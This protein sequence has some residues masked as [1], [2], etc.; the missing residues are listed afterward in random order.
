MNSQ[1]E[2]LAI[3]NRIGRFKSCIFGDSTLKY[4]ISSIYYRVQVLYHTL[5]FKSKTFLFITTG[6]IAI[7]YMLLILFKYE[8]LQVYHDLLKKIGNEH[9]KQDFKRSNNPFPTDKLK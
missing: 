9:F 6:N 8:D 3:E 7:N 1:E 4:S 5:I 2:I